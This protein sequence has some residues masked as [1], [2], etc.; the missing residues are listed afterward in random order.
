MAILA[1]DGVDVR[2]VR[3]VKEALAENAAMGCVVAPRLGMLRGGADDEVLADFSLLTA[4]SVLFDA[5]YVPGGAS[6]V[7]ALA[8]ERDAVEFVTE[9]YRH[10]KPIIATGEGIDLLRACNEILVDGDGDGN[11][12]AKGT[13]SRAEGVLVTSEPATAAFIGTL[14]DTVAEHRFWTRARRNRVGVPSSDETR[15]RAPALASPSRS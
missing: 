7:S 4:S 6:S 3:S 2:S 10:C 12:R 9:A 11:G 15:G 1:A 14:I 8:K 5:V 13:G